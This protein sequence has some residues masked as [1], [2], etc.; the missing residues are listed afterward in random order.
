MYSCAGVW[1]MYNMV[2]YPFNLLAPTIVAGF[3]DNQT[4]IQSNGWSALVNAFALPGAIFGSLLIDRMGPRQTYAFGLVLVAVFG[5]TIGGAM[6]PLR[7]GGTGA[8]AGFVILFGL[9]QCF[10]SVGP[11]NNN[12]VISSE[13]FPTAI[14]GHALGFA[15]AM[16]KTGAAIGT[17]IFPIIQNKFPTVPEGQRAIFL[18]GSG[19]CAVGAV[20]VMLLVP[21]R[22][23]QLEDEDVL[24]REYLEANGW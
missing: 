5:F 9:F 1:F 24:F 16:G 15:A 22:R 19:I 14:R 2:V 21:N 11:G 10:L 23:A 20:W 6:G 4:L 3:A 8:F 13:S 7:S 18:V 17:Q 12:F